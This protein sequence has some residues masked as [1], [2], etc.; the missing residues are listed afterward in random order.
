MKKLGQAALEFLSTYGFAFLIILV[1]IGALSYFGVL[2]PGN[3]LPDRCTISPQFSCEEA[4]VFFNGG[5]GTLALNLQSNLGTSITMGAINLTSEFVG[6]A[7]DEGCQEITST[8]APFPVVTSQFDVDS[9][10]SS[11]DNIRASDIIEIKCDMAANSGSAS[12]L[13][14]PGE[15]VRVAFTAQY[16]EAGDSFA[17]TLQ[18]EIYTTVQPGSLN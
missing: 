12:G 7:A 1:M 2:S 9:N 8:T 10:P 3:L 15:K 14:A 5:N 6:H 16:K 17:K 13:P 11:L 4:V 18:G